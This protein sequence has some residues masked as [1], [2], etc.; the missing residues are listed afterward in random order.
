MEGF[1]RQQ[2][3]GGGNDKDTSIKSEDNF[4]SHYQE[5]YKQ[6]SR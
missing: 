1:S 4:N 6:T 2:Y 3:R 5:N